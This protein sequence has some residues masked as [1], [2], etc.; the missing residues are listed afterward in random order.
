MRGYSH[1]GPLDS[2]GSHGTLA[3]ENLGGTPVSKSSGLAPGRGHVDSESFRL[4]L[5]MVRNGQRIAQISGE[6]SR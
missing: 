2:L 6:N 5:C 1:H 3:L 4:A